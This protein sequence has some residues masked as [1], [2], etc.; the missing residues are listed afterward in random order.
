MKRYISSADEFDCH[1]DIAFGDAPAR[2]QAAK[3][4]RSRALQEVYLY[5]PDPTVRQDLAFNSHLPYDIAKTLSEDSDFVVRGAVAG[6]ANTPTSIL[7]ELAKDENSTVRAYAASNWNAP[8]S[9]LDVLAQDPD[10]RVRATAMRNPNFG[11]Y[12]TAE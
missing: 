1:P 7:E 10:K 9:L 11:E 5:D 4:T 6:S 2:C 3:F 8:A 12:P